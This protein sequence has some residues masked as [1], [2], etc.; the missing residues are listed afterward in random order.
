MSMRFQ[1]I[2][3]TGRKG[4]ACFLVEASGCR[5]LLDL[6]QGPQRG[7][8]PPVA[9]IGDPVDALLFSHQHPDHIGGLGLYDEIGRPPLVATA[10]V[11]RAIAAA[12]DLTSQTAPLGERIEYPGFSVVTGRSGHAPGGIWLH[13]DTPDRS[14]LYMGDH[15][16]HSALY[17]Y[18]APP[19]A[20]AVIIDGSY[21]LDDTAQSQRRQDLFAHLDRP[22]LLPAPP[23]GRA[24]EMAL[25]LMRA[26]RVPHLCPTVREAARRMAA[27]DH[28][29]LQPGVRAEVQYL[30]E[31]APEAGPIDAVTIAAGGDLES[32]P[33]ASLAEQWLQA[34]EPI[35][36]TGYVAEGTRAA[37]LVAAGRALSLR[38]NVHPIL[39]ELRALVAT[40]QPKML[41]PA[42]SRTTLAEWRPHFE[43]THLTFA[44][45]MTEIPA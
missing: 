25:E 17:A 27:D 33:A 19:P 10:P 24:V 9:R 36:F 40:L 29:W 4:P 20:D 28:A 12:F 21:G 23:A 38:W 37:D 7:L 42:F 8:L 41:V 5:L 1:A 2:S 6:G 14:L 31:T 18:D 16:A 44:G 3:G 11:A 45:D 30:A 15:C 35:I 34:G 13:L 32:G 39:S 43:G 22:V 26:G